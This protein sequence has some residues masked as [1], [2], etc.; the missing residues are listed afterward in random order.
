MYSPITLFQS[1]QNHNHLKPISYMLKLLICGSPLHP[2]SDHQHQHQNRDHQD[3]VPMSLSCSAGTSPSSTP[4]KSRKTAFSRNH[5]NKDK[6]PYATRGLDKFSALLADLEEKR[7][8]IYEQSAASEDISFVRFVYKNSNDLVPIIV[9]LKDSEKEADKTNKSTSRTAGNEDLLV[10]EKQSTQN[11]ET[12]HDK[13]PIA[14]KEVKKSQRSEQSSKVINNLLQPWSMVKFDKLR[15]PSYYLPVVVI[16]ILILLAF[17]G[18]S[19]AI[20]CTSIGWYVVPT[21]KD[22]STRKSSAVNKKDYVKK[23]SEKN[24]VTEGVSSP[25]INN[26]SPRQQGHRR[27]W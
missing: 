9:K 14:V 20:L 24:L 3:E 11:S 5:N 1:N 21:L 12:T 6:N 23:L 22:S 8:K 19:I 25:R 18:R 13:F 27:S 10:K 16:V 15:R 2:S 4:K 17:F 26:K 7:Q